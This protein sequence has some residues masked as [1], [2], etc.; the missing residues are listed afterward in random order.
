MLSPIVGPS[1][2]SPDAVM[3]LKFLMASSPE[4]H[5]EWLATPITRM[6]LSALEESAR[7]RA[8]QPNLQI[9]DY[10]QAVGEIIGMQRAVVALKDPVAFLG[11]LGLSIS[12]EP[13]TLPTPSY[14]APEPPPESKAR[15]RSKQ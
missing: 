4:A 11:H 6:I 1:Q 10:A 8:P 12:A 9:T 3:D 15:S 2:G 7:G 14:M 5:Q 13:M